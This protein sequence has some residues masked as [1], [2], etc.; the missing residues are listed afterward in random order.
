MQNVNQL[1]ADSWMHYVETMN[2]R[3]EKIDSFDW[4]KLGREWWLEQA[5]TVG[6]DERQLKFAV[7]R[8]R[9]CSQTQSARES[10]YHDD[11]CGS[12]RQHGYRTARTRKVMMLLELASLETRGGYDGSVTRQEHR[13]ILTNLARGSDPSIKIRALEALAKFDA[14][15]AER[16]AAEREARAS[17]ESLGELFDKLAKINPVRAAVLAREIGFGWDL[18]DGLV[19]DALQRFDGERRKLQARWARMREELSSTANGAAKPPLAA[20]AVGKGSG[21]DVEASA[22]EHG[23]FVRE[24]QSAG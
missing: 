7:A 6:A 13:R 3:E 14:D 22:S 20:K 11:G 2:A 15:A 4:G 23:D 10:G 1:T 9:G 12:I 17:Q 5:T 21:D 18:P 8:Y 16:E 19:E 24:G